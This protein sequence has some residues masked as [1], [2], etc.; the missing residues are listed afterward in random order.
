MH[1]MAWQR[2]MQAEDKKEEEKTGAGKW[3]KK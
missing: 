3:M 2:S 1:I